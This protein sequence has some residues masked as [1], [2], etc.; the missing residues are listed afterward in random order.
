MSLKYPQD[1]SK[2]SP[3][4]LKNIPK[5]SRQR[6]TG[7]CLTARDTGQAQRATRR[8]LEG[9]E[10]SRNLTRQPV[11][12]K[13]AAGGWV[14]WLPYS[15]CWQVSLVSSPRAVVSCQSHETSLQLVA[16]SFPSF[17]PSLHLNSSHII[18][19]SHQASLA[20]T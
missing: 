11:A 13:A 8:R 20:M 4:Y 5:I 14:A 2:I 16:L 18:A 19:V 15:L 1:I 12:E 7:K 6:D 9:S 3:R 10:G 17:W